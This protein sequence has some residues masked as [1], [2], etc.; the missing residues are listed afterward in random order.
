MAS[1]RRSFSGCLP[2]EKLSRLCETLADSAGEVAYV[3]DFGCDDHQV[4]YVDVSAD[5]ALQ[6]TCQRTLQPF[7]FPVRVSTRLGMIRHEQDEAGLPPDYE[8]LLVPSDGRINP[9]DLIEEELL[10]AM[11][12]VAINPDSSMEPAAAL[13][14]V[15]PADSPEENPFAVLR[16][17]KS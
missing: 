8:P 12:L 15:D 5:T 4:C 7:A 11:P 13:S 3:L 14:E 17:L 6:L 9:A 10:L 2:V 1:S 16:R